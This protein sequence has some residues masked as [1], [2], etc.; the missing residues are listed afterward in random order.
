[1]VPYVQKLDFNPDGTIRPVKL[2]N[3]GVGALRPITITKPNLALKGTASASSTMEPV[4]IQPKYDPSLNRTET[5]SPNLAV[6]ESNGSR[7]MAAP[8]DKAPW[9]QLDLGKVEQISHTEAYFVKPTA[10]HAYRL[11]ASIDGKTWALVTNHPKVSIRS[12]HVDNR[13]IHARYL[14][15]HI[16]H[17]EPGLWEFRVYPK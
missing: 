5:F 4:K 12:P 2:T 15:I 8:N 17:G 13:P 14:R 9:W 3:Q 6:D 1:M 10:G 11:E 7:W 16:I